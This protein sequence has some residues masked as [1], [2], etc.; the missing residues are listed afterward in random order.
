MYL[1]YFFLYPQVKPPQALTL[2]FSPDLPLNYVDWNELHP[3]TESIPWVSGNAQQTQN[4]Q[5]QTPPQSPLLL[6]GP[7]RG[8]GEEPVALSCFLCSVS[9]PGTE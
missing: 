6:V 1:C 8:S 4:W 2:V 3:Q 5:G 7:R 9:S